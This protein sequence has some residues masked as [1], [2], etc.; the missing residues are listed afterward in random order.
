MILYLS[1]THNCQLRC[2][3]CYAGDKYHKPMSKETIIKAIEFTLQ[4]PMQKLEFGFFGG[5]PLMEWELFQFATYQIEKETEKREIKLVKTFTTN[6]IL[7]NKEKVQWLKTHGFYV[8][9]SI[10]GND[11]MHNTHRHYSN[12]KES[13]QEVEQGILELQKEYKK[14]EY[15]VISVVTPQNITHLN[16]SLAYL[17]QELNI[18][19]IHLALNYFG[20]WR[21]K[22]EEYTQLYHDVG[23]YVIEQYRKSR[24]INLDI[25]DDK[26]KT[27]IES[28]CATC[29]FGEQKI[30]VA[31]SGN[32][33]PCE[34]LIG[35]DTEALSIG[36]VYSGFDHAK[37]NRLIEQRGN[38]NEECRTCP[39]KERCSN[40][41]GCT[42]YTLTESIDKTNGV[43]CFFQK[44]FIEV[45]DNVA[46]TLYAEK[47]KLFLQKFYGRCLP[48][49]SS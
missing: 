45:A 37:R 8:V 49:H 4:L 38:S 14:G 30:A 28:N 13:F 24:E 42:N 10:D 6:G 34:R 18:T 36:N 19:D 2:D 25:I 46:S 20:E 11:K 29:S 32:I 5:E 23:D 47:N 39:I 35:E 43:V 41:C 17:H 40:S 15:A 44:L 21:D 7:L 33:Y 27:A 1:L 48:L 16:E 31:P 22:T 12:K 26:I 3:Y 9:V